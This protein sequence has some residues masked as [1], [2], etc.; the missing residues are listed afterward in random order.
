MSLTGPDPEAILKVLYKGDRRREESRTGDALLHASGLCYGPKCPR[1]LY[2]AQGM[3]EEGVSFEEAP[4]GNM[5]LVW[6]FGRAAERHVRDTLLL[7]KSIREAAYGAWA[8]RCG[9]TRTRGHFPISAERC[10]RCGELPI[11]YREVTLSDTDRS[12]VGNPDL[13]LK[14]GTRYTVLEIKSMKKDSSGQH[15][16]FKDIEA[17]IPRHVEQAT[18]YVRL[19]ER[20]GLPMH[21]KPVILYVLKD[22]DPRKWYKALIPSDTL[23]AQVDA[24]VAAGRSVAETYHQARQAGTVPAKIPACE[25]NM[26]THKK[27][28]QVWSECRANG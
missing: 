12:M 10:T 28:C 7:D 20:N 21:R 16:G 18:H 14:Q 11:N 27:T 1:M 23:Q 9:Q 6:A 22:F 26:E 8:C 3:K 19:G 25:A 5:R 17:P 4:F 24:D 13:L 2:L 15:V